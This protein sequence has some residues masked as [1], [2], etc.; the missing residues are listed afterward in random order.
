M[1]QLIASPLLGQYL[2]LRPGHAKGVAIPESRFEE[3]RTA[4]T[5]DRSAPAWLAEATRAAWQMPM[6][7]G[8]L[9]DNLIVRERSTYGYA[10]AS[11]EINLGCDHDCGFCYLGEKRFEC[12]DWDDKTHACLRAWAGK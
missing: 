1:H 11:W 4:V 8:P 10:K 5:E 12:L 7:T 3:L 6:P 9:Q 2:L